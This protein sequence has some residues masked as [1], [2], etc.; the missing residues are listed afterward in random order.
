MAPVALLWFPCFVKGGKTP[1]RQKRRAGC[2]K[3]LTHPKTKKFD[4]ALNTSI[5]PP[6]VSTP[7]RSL[8]LPYLLSPNDYF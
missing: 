2:Q 8:F 4:Q 3:R 1:F 6:Q 7:T 5:S